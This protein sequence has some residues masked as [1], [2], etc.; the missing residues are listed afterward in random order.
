MGPVSVLLSEAAVSKTIMSTTG[1]VI[2]SDEDSIDEV[3]EP[4]DPSESVTTSGTRSVAS[5]S[6][7][8]SPRKWEPSHPPITW[9]LYSAND[10]KWDAL[11]EDEIDN[12]G[13]WHLFSY[14]P[15]YS[16]KKK[17]TGHAKRREDLIRKE[18]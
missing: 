6:L 2:G 12:P 16:D 15:K 1:K 14:Q 3:G 8:G 10:K 7:P 9:L 18:G 4:P 17:Y 11:N 13:N 5:S